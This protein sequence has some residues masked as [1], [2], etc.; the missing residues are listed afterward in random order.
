MLRETDDLVTAKPSTIGAR[1][2]TPSGRRIYQVG[3]LHATFRA[4]AGSFVACAE[5]AA[6]SFWCQSTVDASPDADG[7]ILVVITPD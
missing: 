1:D 7:A 4:P 6:G 5:T 2:A 3:D